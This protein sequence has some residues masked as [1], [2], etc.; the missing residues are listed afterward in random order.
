MVLASENVDFQVFYA[1]T[2]NPA[3]NIPPTT[4]GGTVSFSFAPTYSSPTASGPC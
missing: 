2:G 4:P 3:N 1:Y